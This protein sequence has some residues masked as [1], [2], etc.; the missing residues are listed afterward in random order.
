MVKPEKGRKF[1]DRAVADLGRM[2]LV[3]FWCSPPT[4]VMLS[5]ELTQLRVQVFY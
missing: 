5:D 2:V 3:K 1:S 4:S